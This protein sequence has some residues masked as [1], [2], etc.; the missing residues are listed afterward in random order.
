MIIQAPDLKILRR[1][2]RNYRPRSFIISD[3]PL[4]FEWIEKKRIIEVP[5]GFITD[6]A[7]IP[8]LLRGV[9]AVN[10]DHRLAAI[11]HDFLYRNLGAL[12]QLRRTLTYTRKEAD[13]IFYKLMI[14]EGVGAAQA[15]TMHQAV[16]RF[17]WL[18]SGEWANGR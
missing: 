11:V 17:G 3:P 5:R 18:Y 13:Q 6:F 16:R 14:S 4:L 1:S 8:R 12:T 9:V 15:W 7:S 2:H 10:D